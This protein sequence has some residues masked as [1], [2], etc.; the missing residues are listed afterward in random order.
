MYSVKCIVYNVYC[1][2]Y[3]VFFP[4]SHC[5]FLKLYPKFSSVNYFTLPLCFTIFYIPAVL[6]IAIEFGQL[7]CI[8][9][10]DN[11]GRIGEFG[12]LREA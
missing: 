3:S 6:Y 5:L 7:G 4:S 12:Q 8:D 9:E 2:V 10:L 1:L 11:L